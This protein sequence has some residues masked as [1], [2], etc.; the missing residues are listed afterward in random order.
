M[1]TELTRSLIYLLLTL[2]S[3]PASSCQM[4]KQQSRLFLRNNWREENQWL[5]SCKALRKKRVV[6]IS[7]T[8]W[9]VLVQMYAIIHPQLYRDDLI[10]PLTINTVAEL[11]PLHCTRRELKSKN[12]WRIGNSLRATWEM[13]GGYGLVS[14]VRQ[15]S[16]LHLTLGVPQLINM[17][18]QTWNYNCYHLIPPAQTSSHWTHLLSEN[19]VHQELLSGAWKVL[20]EESGSIPSTHMVVHNHA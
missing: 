3:R 17:Q 5:P 11:P 13:S 6:L 4:S 14:V 9:W 7:E 10:L 8:A 15:L 19:V 16:S 1:L 12:S 20:A 2:L 18:T